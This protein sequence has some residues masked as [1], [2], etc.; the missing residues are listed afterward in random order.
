MNLNEKIRM[1]EA[2]AELG[3]DVI[4]AG[5]PIASPDD[6][7]SVKAISESLGQCDDTSMICGPARCGLDTIRDQFK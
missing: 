1:A 2:P 5:F 7:E 3:V 4:E 6:L